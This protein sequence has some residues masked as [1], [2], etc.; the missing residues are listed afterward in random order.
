MNINP[1]KERAL[2]GNSAGISVVTLEMGETPYSAR[3]V[4]LPILMP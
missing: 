2:T 1:L 4:S 3:S